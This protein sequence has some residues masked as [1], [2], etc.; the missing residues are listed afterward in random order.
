MSFSLNPRVV[1]MLFK[2]MYSHFICNACNETSSSL[3][4]KESNI[5]ASNT[6]RSPNEGMSY[7]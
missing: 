5:Y 6:F 4:L 7:T 2:K 3:F 1:D